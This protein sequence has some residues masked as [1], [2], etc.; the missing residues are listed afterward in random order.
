MSTLT[1]TSVDLTGNPLTVEQVVAVARDGALVRLTDEALRRMAA[2]RAVVD[3]LAGDVRPHYGIST[4][5]GALAR[6]H[7][8]A[9]RRA[10]LQRSL[11]RSHAA[12]DVMWV[13]LLVFGPF[14]R[15]YCDVSP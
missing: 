3:E 2:G 8:P 10:D 14:L 1:T 5:F 15:P 11:V 6:T 7:I 13:V 4:G 12:A 9:E